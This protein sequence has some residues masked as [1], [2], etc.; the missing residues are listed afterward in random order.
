[1]N[2]LLVNSNDRWQVEKETL[3]TQR[4]DYKTSE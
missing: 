2:Y 4:V 3:D 1:M